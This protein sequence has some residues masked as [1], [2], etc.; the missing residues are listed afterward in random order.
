MEGDIMASEE[1]LPPQSSANLPALRPHGSQLEV[2][3]PGSKLVSRIAGDAYQH[4]HSPSKKHWRIGGY[5][6]NEEAYCRIMSWLDQIRAVGS[7]ITLDDF[8]KLQDDVWVSDFRI[9]RVV[10]PIEIQLSHIDLLNAPDLSQ[11]WCAWTGLNEIDLSHLSNLDTLDCSLNELRVLDL[12]G[13]TNLDYLDCAHNQL[14]ELDLS[15]IPNLTRLSCSGNQ[16]AELN[17]SHVPNLKWLECNENEL[18]ELDLEHVPALSGLECKN[19]RIAELDL[20]SCRTS[21]F[22]LWCDPNVTVLHRPDQ[23]V[24]QSHIDL[25]KL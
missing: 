6:V 11:L 9:V 2:V 15:H 5:E 21:E 19:N 3:R 8:V 24:T 18:T 25:T 22:R 13:V 4:L 17:L 10:F 20:R 12:S 16:L 1:Y 23:T 14:T 7:E